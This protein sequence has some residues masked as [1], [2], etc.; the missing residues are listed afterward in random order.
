MG[1]CKVIR[2]PR[3]YKTS[4]LRFKVKKAT[5]PPSLYELSVIDMN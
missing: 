5:A 4:K 3:K 1:D 2:L